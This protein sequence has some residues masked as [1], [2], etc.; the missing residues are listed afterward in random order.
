MHTSPLLKSLLLQSSDIPQL[1]LVVDLVLGIEVCI[2]DWL[3]VPKF[4][5]INEVGAV[6]VLN[7]EAFCALSIRLVVILRR[8]F[9]RSIHIMTVRLYACTISGGLWY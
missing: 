8:W 6:L 5:G 9:R 3:V 2:Y 4:Q 7:L 1:V